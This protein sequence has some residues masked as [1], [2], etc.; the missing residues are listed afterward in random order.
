M[1]L[2]IG[3]SF[4]PSVLSRSLL[5]AALSI[6]NKKMGG[7]NAALSNE[8]EVENKP[9]YSEGKPM[10]DAQVRGPHIPSTSNP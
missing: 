2:L 8:K 7:R 1:Y 3:I 9:P 4:I 6:I 10:S 5:R